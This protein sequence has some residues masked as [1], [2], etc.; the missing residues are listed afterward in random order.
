MVRVSSALDRVDPDQAKIIW[1]GWA[2]CVAVFQSLVPPGKYA[3][4]VLGFV[5]ATI[6][7][8]LL[9]RLSRLENPKLRSGINNCLTAPL[10]IAAFCI[11]IDDRVG[12]IYCASICATLC[13]C[14]WSEVLVQSRCQSLKNLIGAALICLVVGVAI[15][16]CIGERHG[17]F[18]PIGFLLFSVPFFVQA[19]G[20]INTAAIFK[21]A[22]LSALI[23]A[24][25]GIAILPRE[26]FVRSLHVSEQCK[27]FAGIALGIFFSLRWTSALLAFRVSGSLKRIVC[28]VAV[29]SLEAS[30][31][32]AIYFLLNA[33]GGSAQFSSRM[34]IDVAELAVG[35]AILCF[36]R[37][38]NGRRATGV[39]N[40]R[41]PSPS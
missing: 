21:T 6:M 20:A 25:L 36:L 29:I 1:S 9:D 26:N 37:L 10:L 3:A 15:Q 35:S 27:N 5:T 12:V 40:T 41:L 39:T 19:R 16:F 38:E 31:I 2:V 13:W 7:W 17:I 33:S 34:A 23:Y 4:P 28:I 18:G 11:K 14:G 24:A 8:L 30:F 32:C 22:P